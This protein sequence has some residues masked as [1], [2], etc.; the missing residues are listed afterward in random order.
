MRF[1]ARLCVFLALLCASAAQAQVVFDAKSTA[2]TNVA[3]PTSPVTHTAMTVGAALS[4]GAL[5]AILSSADPNFFSSIT[6]IHWDS[7]GTNQ[8]MTA[9]PSA[10]ISD[11][12]VASSIMYGLLNPTAGNKTFSVSFSGFPN[13]LIIELI[14]FSGVLQTSIAAAFPHGASAKD[15]TGTSSTASLTVTS[16]TGDIA[17]AAHANDT[18]A[19]FTTISGTTIFN[20]VGA[21]PENAAANYVAGSGTAVLTAAMSAADVWVAAGTDIAAASGGGPTCPMTRSLMGVGC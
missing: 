1:L 11:A 7:T 8:A 14:S 13:G 6:S 20:V 2:P 10:S 16:P 12:G 17:I 21:G 5:I 15:V 19:T 4:N 18:G 3:T 9:I